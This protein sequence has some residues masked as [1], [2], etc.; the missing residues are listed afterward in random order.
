MIL[1]ARN[2]ISLHIDHLDGSFPSERVPGMFT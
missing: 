1:P 2:M